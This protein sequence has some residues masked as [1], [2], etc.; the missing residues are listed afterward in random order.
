MLLA[1]GT[2][3]GYCV[4]KSGP[5]QLVLERVAADAPEDDR[6]LVGRFSGLSFTVQ[7][8]AARHGELKARG[9]I[10]ASPPERQAWGGILATLQDP[11]GNALQI[12][13]MPEPTAAGS[14]PSDLSSAPPGR[15]TRA[16]A[17][18]EVM[19][20]LPSRSLARTLAFY[21]RLGFE[22]ALVADDYAITRRGAIELHFFPHPALEPEACYAG[23]YVRL[24]DVDGLHAAF[25]L[26]GLP[27]QGIP[28]ME[29]VENKPW[30]MREF[31]LLDEDGN[32]LRFGRD[33]PP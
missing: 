8:I 30:G 19:P 14:V 2:A 26:A 15:Q 31:A 25:R 32:L 3:H 24:A 29:A 9:V 17:G 20:I 21:R 33:A 16:R 18:P 10:F 23:V 11:A 13:Q 28:R 22:G 7:D 27:T 5:T 1:D 6:A 12:V 4:F